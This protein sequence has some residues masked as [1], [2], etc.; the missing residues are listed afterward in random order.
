MKPVLYILTATL[1]IA[2]CSSNTTTETKTETAAPVPAADNEKVINQLFDHFNKHEWD[3]L[4]SLYA[5]SADF[6]DP[7]LGN[8]IVKQTRQQIIDKYKQLNGF[9]PDINIKQPAL[10]PSGANIVVAEFIS[11]GTAPD[12]TKM[13]L[14]ICT[15]FTIEGGKITKDYTY[16]DNMAPPATAK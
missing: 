5:D 11:S 9:L 13:D 16:Y 7:A 2:S 10:Y 1:L 4:G 8:G 15:I 12:G 3:K 6:K 14:P